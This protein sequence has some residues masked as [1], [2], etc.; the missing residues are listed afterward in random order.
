MYTK[1]IPVKDVLLWSGI[2]VSPSRVKRSLIGVFDWDRLTRLGCLSTSDD[3]RSGRKFSTNLARLS[4]HS[5]A[6]TDLEWSFF[7]IVGVLKA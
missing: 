5:D 2:H 6:L 3:Y 1:I 4:N 7:A